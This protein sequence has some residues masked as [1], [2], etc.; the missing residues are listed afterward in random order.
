MTNQHRYLL[1]DRA[2]LQIFGV[3]LVAVMGVASITPAFPEFIA[4]FQITAREVG[5]LIVAFTLPGIILTP[6]TGILADRLGRKV[7]LIPSLILFGLAGF[8]C[9]FTRDFFWLL[10]FR[11]IQGIGAS[12]LASI[13]VT[14]IGDLFSGERRVAAMGYNASV[15]SIGTASY[16]AIGGLLTTLGWQFV[17]VL[18]LLS[19]PL[20]VVILLRLDNPEPTVQTSLHAY[21]SNV[22]RTINRNVVWALFGVNVLL[23]VILYGA[24]L[25]YFPLLLGTRMN[26]GSVIIGASMSL[27]SAV[28]ALTSF[29]LPLVNRLFK[30]RTQ[31]LVAASLYCI[32]MLLLSQAFGWSLILLGLVVFGLGHGILIPAVQN[33]LVGLASI[34]ERAAFMS[35]NSMVL[36]IGQTIGPILIAVFYHF[37][38]ITFSFYGGA[39][40]AGL[41]LLLVL[42]LVQNQDLAKR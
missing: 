10:V 15:L 6:I 38:G 28:T 33:M 4:F 18:P 27:M 5:W 14:L 21:F 8:A 39:I 40:A 12:S 23:F 37:G 36:R 30:P 29:Q 31:L 35:I 22:W 11:L 19:L 13:N 25:T 34:Q 16:P 26:V 2:L 1:K 42:L 9:F 41:I 32:S 3:T 17:F 24:Y 20:A 7:I